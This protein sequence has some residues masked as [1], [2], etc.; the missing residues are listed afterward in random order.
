M[1][2]LNKTG[3]ETRSGRSLQ[4]TFVDS[5]LDEGKAPDEV[6][7]GFLPSDAVVGIVAP[8]QSGKSLLVTQLASCVA[9][10]KPF[11][12]RDCKQGL[13]V[14]LCSEGKSGLKPRL[15]AVELH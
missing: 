15:Q 11:F 10:G 2:P 5:L 4:F 8:S 1:L 3:T 7:E 14:Y 13:V 6:V 12:G 9:T